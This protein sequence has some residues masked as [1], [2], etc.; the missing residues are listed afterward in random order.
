VARALVILGAHRR[1][2]VLCAREIQNSIEESVHKLLSDQIVALGLA[3]RYKVTQRGIVGT[4]GTD[5]IF[6][7]LKTNITK[8]KSMEG[9]D[10]VWI[11]EAEKVSKNSWQT[12]IPT[13]RKPGSEIWITFNPDEETD[14]TYAR[15]VSSPPPDAIV[16]KVN[17]RDNPYF[18]EELRREMEYLKSV[19]YDA[20][21]HVWEGE[22]RKRSDAQILNGKWVVEWFEPQ[23]GWDGPYYGADWGFAN[24]PTAAVRMWVN[25]TDPRGPELMIEHEA[26][27]LRVDIDK[28]PE[29]FDGMPQ[30]RE[31]T[32]RADN[33]RP[34]TI[35]YMQNHGY[36]SVVA[37]SKWPGSVEDGITFL[38]S[39]RRIV[40]HTRCT[41]TAQEA[42]LYS[43]KVDRLSGDVLAE[44]VDKHNHCW[45][46][47]RYGLEPLIKGSGL[48][49]LHYTQGLV[50][51]QATEE[52]KIRS[53][54]GG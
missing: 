3:D 42:R 35:S 51:E 47:V 50:V 1:I 48:G 13:I 17:W 30:A 14:P 6:A 15:F 38:R 49:M 18:P 26:Y 43:Y 52:D 54:L 21:L 19:D 39:F 36:P 9:I 34:E 46:A 28:T 4:N 7:G 16:R 23:P 20:Y 53:M 10:I 40:I 37:C 25:L 5:F 44:I 41:H 8:I 45:D 29:L 24:D 2:R 27:G 32:I 12:L 22:C 33:A 11:E 31:H